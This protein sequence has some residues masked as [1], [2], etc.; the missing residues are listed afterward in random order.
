MKNGL[1]DEGGLD[2]ASMI[3][4]SGGESGPPPPIRTED[5]G[6]ISG[7]VGSAVGVDDPDELALLPA[8]V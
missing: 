8:Y 6:R 4:S 2:D 7:V 3:V 5:D 1:G